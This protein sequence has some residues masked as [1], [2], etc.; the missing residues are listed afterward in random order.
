MRSAFGRLRLPSKVLDLVDGLSERHNGYGPTDVIRNLKLPFDPDAR[1]AQ[2]AL[3]HEPS[4][5]RMN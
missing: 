3:A 2:D 4:G 1:I 5:S